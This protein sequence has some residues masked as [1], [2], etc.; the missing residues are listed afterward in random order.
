MDEASKCTLSHSSRFRWAVLSIL[1]WFLEAGAAFAAPS[2]LVNWDANLETWYA[3]GWE[4]AP[5]SYVSVKG[6]V[7][8]VHFV[9]DG[10]CYRQWEPITIRGAAWR[11]AK[12]VQFILNLPSAADPPTHAGDKHAYLAVVK[13]SAEAWT[14]AS[15]WNARL[16]VLDEPAKPTVPQRD[17]KANLIDRFDPQVPR[18]DPFRIR[19]IAELLR[20]ACLWHRLGAHKEA[21]NAVK[22]LVGKDLP[23]IEPALMHLLADRRYVSLFARWLGDGN[24]SKFLEDLNQLLAQFPDSK[25]W[26]NRIEVENVRDLL[27]RTQSGAKTAINALPER[28]RPWLARWQSAAPPCALRMHACESNTYDLL[29]RLGYEWRSRLLNLE[30]HP[31][32][33]MHGLTGEDEP[34]EGALSDNSVMNAWRVDMRQWASWREDA[35][36]PLI[37]MLDLDV[38]MPHEDDWCRNSPEGF[39]LPGEDWQ[40]LLPEKSS[41]Q[42]IDGPKLTERDWRHHN[43]P[44]PLSCRDLAMRL[45]LNMLPDAGQ[46]FKP[47]IDGNNPEVRKSIKSWALNW[48]SLLK[49]SSAWRAGWT[50]YQSVSTSREN[51]LYLVAS[52]KAPD[53]AA[54][55]QIQDYLLQHLNDG[56][57]AG[58]Y[59]ASLKDDI[60]EFLPRYRAAAELWLA[61]QEKASDAGNSAASKHWPPPS[62]LK[63][64][65]VVY[66]MLENPELFQ[67][68]LLKSMTTE[69]SAQPTPSPIE[70]IFDLLA[71]IPPEE[72]ARALPYLSALLRTAQQVPA[73]QKDFLLEMLF[74]CLTDVRTFRE[75]IAWNRFP[76][77]LPLLIDQ[78]RSVLESLL[79]DSTPLSRG[80]M[81]VKFWTAW[82]LENL[83][84]SKGYWDWY[85][86]SDLSEADKR[87]VLVDRC[88]ARLHD[89]LLPSLPSRP[90]KLEKK[91]NSSKGR[92]E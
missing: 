13:E 78:N 8:V 30:N 59:L 45:L 32:A 17:A 2:D 64:R 57:L 92:R 18:D 60:G 55:Q 88:L 39:V 53:A 21:V 89:E 91:G 34:L 25:V 54:H 36:L 50:F 19:H 15:I 46:R 69:G 33:K 51:S 56:Y 22:G 84:D 70:T 52:L 27:Q 83:A 74:Q 11:I 16:I 81:C 76:G 75:Q 12:D 62:D 38:A 23:L 7:D 90:P 66:S 28:F 67:S 26:Q 48:H 85:G 65:L 40:E 87:T 80:K 61:G 79:R 3:V 41:G 82:I 43:M 5:V 6:K 68:C 47:Y 44:R 72:G 29:F 20:N 86:K 14:L 37:E 71:L 49:G 58:R 24:A 35:L 10:P 31:S 9:C 4:G 42:G 77:I 1:I 73:E 63:E